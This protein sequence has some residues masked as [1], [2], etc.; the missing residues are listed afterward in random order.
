MSDSERR[1]VLECYEGQ[2]DK[3]FN[4]RRVL[5][6]NC[7]DD[8]TVLRQACQVFSRECL[9]IGNIEVFLEAVTIA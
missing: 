7:Q 4:N 8:L 5:E 2:K 6:S 1:E 3:V 9:A